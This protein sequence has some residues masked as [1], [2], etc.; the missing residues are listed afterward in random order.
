MLNKNTLITRKLCLLQKFLI[1]SITDSVGR[2]LKGNFLNESN[3]LT[4]FFDRFMNYVKFELLQKQ[5]Y[6]KYVLEKMLN[7]FVRKYCSTLRRPSSE[8]MALHSKI[9]TR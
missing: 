8:N 1:L 5:V 7:F 9:R 3:E 2:D 6:I 4:L